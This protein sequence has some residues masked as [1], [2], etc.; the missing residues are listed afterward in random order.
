[1]DY[2]ISAETWEEKR[3]R[4]CRPSLVI[5]VKQKI[6]QEIEDSLDEEQVKKMLSD[7]K[8]KAESYMSNNRNI[9]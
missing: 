3:R 2:K 1:L 9:S 5:K 6:E 8:S 4:F 7:V